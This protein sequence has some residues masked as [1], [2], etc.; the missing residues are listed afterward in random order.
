MV[1]NEGKYFIEGILSFV[2]GCE[3]FAFGAR[4]TDR[5]EFNLLQNSE[6]PSVYTKLSCYLPWIARQYGLAYDS[7][8]DDNCY[9]GTGPSPPYNTDCR[10]NPGTDLSNKEHKCIFPFYYRGQGPYDRCMLFEEDGFVYPVFRCPTRN[11]TT[12]FKGTDINHFETTISTTEGICYDLAL[13]IATC[14]NS[15]EDGGP[16]CQRVL[17]PNDTT[18]P[19]YL[20]LPQF[21][22]CKNDCPGGIN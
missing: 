20:R 21:S 17:D 2:K 14:D 7:V 10:Q 8:L 12:K 16:G 18:C 1:K 6:N 22:T 13:A 4:D 15:M 3:Q 19:S 11:I 9:K 5:T